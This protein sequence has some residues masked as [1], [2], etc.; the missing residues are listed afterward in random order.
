M[1]SGSVSPPNLLFFQIVLAILGHLYFHV[2]FNTNLSIS[3]KISLLEFDQNCNELT[4]QFGR[5]ACWQYWV[6]QSVCYAMPLNLFRLSLIFLTMF[7]RFQFINLLLLFFF[8]TSFVKFILTLFFLILL[9]METFSKFQFL[10]VHFWYTEIQLIL[11]FDLVTLLNLFI[12]SNNCVC[13]CLCVYLEF[14]T[15]DLWIRTVLFLYFHTGIF[16]FL[17]F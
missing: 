15:N 10:M 2:N 3:T 14:S 16:I 12:G 11:H 7:Y 13:M 6:S 1:K 5:I 4:D 17:S 8:P 9:W